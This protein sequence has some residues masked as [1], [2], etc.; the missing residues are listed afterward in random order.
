MKK[1]YQVFKT[2]YHTLLQKE[3]A[4]FLQNEIKQLKVNKAII[5]N[6]IIISIF[7]KCNSIS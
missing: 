2:H 5:L 3:S 4:H 1:V 6:I 7:L